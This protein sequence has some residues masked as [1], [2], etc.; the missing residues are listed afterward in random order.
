MRNI[1]ASLKRQPQDTESVTTLKNV[2][3]AIKTS[4][5]AFHNFRR[6]VTLLCA[7]AV[8]FAS[9]GEPYTGEFGDGYRQ[10][11]KEMADMLRKLASGEITEE[12][13]R[14]R[15]RLPSEKEN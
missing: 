3:V 14:K 9:R 1:F 13:C 12:M 6:D 2:Q 11:Q 15:F 4:Q 5:S 8:E 7:D 10:A